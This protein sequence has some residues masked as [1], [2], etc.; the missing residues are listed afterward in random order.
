MRITV[1]EDAIS[2]VSLKVE[3]NSRITFKMGIA[4]GQYETA[5]IV[6]GYAHFKLKKASCCK[7][8]YVYVVLEDPL[9][10]Q[11]NY[12]SQMLQLH[13][14]VSKDLYERQHLND[15]LGNP[16]Y[17]IKLHDCN[18]DLQPMTCGVFVFGRDDNCAECPQFAKMPSR[19]QL[20]GL[21]EEAEPHVDVD[22]VHFDN[23]VSDVSSGMD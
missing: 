9:G 20:D 17:Y 1:I 23:E 14:H 12:E 21:P 18:D 3:M 16:Q 5:H 4:S 22:V 15:F 6:C 13:R 7:N 8:V 10:E 19:K 2:N 11:V